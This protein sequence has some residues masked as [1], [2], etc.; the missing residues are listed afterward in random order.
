VID[1]TVAICAAD[2]QHIVI[3]SDPGDAGRLNPTLPRIDI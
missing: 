2:R 3:T 1:A